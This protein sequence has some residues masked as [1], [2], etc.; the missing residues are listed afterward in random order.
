MRQI[1]VARAA[2]VS[3]SWIS[4]IER[5]LAPDVSLLLLGVVLA[6][7]GLDLSVR[8]FP[9]GVPLRDAGHRSLLSR[10]RALLPAGTPW[11]LEVPLP[12]PGDQRAWDA[13][14][15]LWGLRV[16]IEAETGPTDLQALERR[17]MLKARDGAWTA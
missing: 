7:V 12:I 10:F 5:G 2:G 13:L 11:R 4:R 3:A 16:G 1:D 15:G 6:V 17:I 8:A 14:T 9:D